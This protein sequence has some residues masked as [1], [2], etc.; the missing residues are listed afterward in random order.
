M[1]FQ[2]GKLSRV[3]RFAVYFSAPFESPPIVHLGLTGLDIDQRDTS[4]V[5]LAATVITES[6]F[7]AEIGT[8]RETRVYSIAF[9]WL[10]LGA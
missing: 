2:R 7:T 3:F 10:A 9:S 8:W 6:G 5:K 4:R 1:Q